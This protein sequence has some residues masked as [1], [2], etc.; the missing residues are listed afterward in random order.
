MSKFYYILTAA[1][2][3]AF[4]VFL[5]L[6]ALYSGVYFTLAIIFGTT[7]YHL[8]VRLAV[9]GLVSLIPKKSR[10]YVPGNYLKASVFLQKTLDFL[11]IKRWKSHVITFDKRLFDVKKLGAE[12]VEYQ[13]KKAELL[14]LVI[15]PLSYCSLL[16]T[17]FT[18]DPL[19]YFWIFFV[20]AFAAGMID[21]VSVVVQRYNLARC[22][23]IFKMLKARR[24]EGEKPVRK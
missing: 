8:A 21:F 12:E 24:A 1:C 14:H 15:I 4:C 22:E 20:T 10:I 9:A 3:A 19:F 5:P 18:G 16:F 7:L 2:L 17:L 11:Q 23:K 6:A 13:M